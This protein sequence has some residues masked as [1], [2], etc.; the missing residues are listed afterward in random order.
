MANLR[1]LC[2]LSMSIKLRLSPVFC[3]SFVLNKG[4]L[5]ECDVSMPFISH[6]LN[7]GIENGGES[8]YLSFEN[9]YAV[10]QLFFAPTRFT[11]FSF[12]II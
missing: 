11:L 9:S 5:F 6:L 2:N 4:F 1:D 7:L 8:S 12:F 3:T 10:L